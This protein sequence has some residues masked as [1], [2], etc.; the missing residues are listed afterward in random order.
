MKILLIGAGN[1]GLAMLRGLDSYDIEIVEKS[2]SRRESIKSDY[3]NLRVY[4]SPP[5]IEWICGYFGYKTQALN[6]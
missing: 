2:S 1:M 4:D 6:D 3:P 5:E